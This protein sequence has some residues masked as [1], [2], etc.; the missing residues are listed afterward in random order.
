[1]NMPKLGKRRHSPMK[2]R[3]EAWAL[4]NDYTANPNLVKHALAVEAA[5]RWYAGYFKQ[6]AAETE[7]WGVTGLLHDF[8]YEKFPTPQAPDGHPYA[9]DK[10]LTE[11]GYSQDIRTAIMAHASYTGVARESLMAKTLFAVDELTGMI[12]AAAL[13]RPDKSIAALEA[14]SVKKRMKDKAFARS[15]NRDDILNG[16]AELGMELEQHIM[17]VICAMRGMAGQLGL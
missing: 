16:S 17:N 11:L 5:M 8:D 6:D 10:I 9:G 7:K 15:V 1:M 3:E 12:T 2:T 13:V 14:S 4:L